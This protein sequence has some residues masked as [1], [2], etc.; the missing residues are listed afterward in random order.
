MFQPRPFSVVPSQ[1]VRAQEDGREGASTLSSRGRVLIVEDEYF[2]ALDIE[3][4]LSSVGFTVV[5][6]AT[7]AEEAT[8]MAE[9]ERPDVV[10]MDI[11]LAGPRD[12]IEAAAE[13]RNRLGIRSLFATAHSDGAT[14]ARGDEAASPLGWL[15]KPYTGSEVVLAVTKAIAR[16]RCGI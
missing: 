12:G 13:I 7:T 9:A 3:D 6:I 10:L 8:R 15:T 4:A 16:V 1:A 2:V 5:G 11:R 14:R